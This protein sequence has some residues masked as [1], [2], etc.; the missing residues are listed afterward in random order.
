MNEF[1]LRKHIREILN[2][3]L[4]TSKKLVQEEFKKSINIVIKE[5]FE[6]SKFIK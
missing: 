3:Y 6:K 2:I 4:N 1:I 5:A